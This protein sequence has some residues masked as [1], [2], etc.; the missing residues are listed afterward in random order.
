MDKDKVRG[1]EK[2]QQDKRRRDEMV[3]CIML[4]SP[5]GGHAERQQS[6]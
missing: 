1:E 3:I 5:R 2:R 6:F 4:P